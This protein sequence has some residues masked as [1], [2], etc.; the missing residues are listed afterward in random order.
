MYSQRFSVCLYHSDHEN[1]TTKTLRIVQCDRKRILS[2]NCEALCHLDKLRI[3]AMCNFI[4][5][6]DVWMC[7]SVYWRFCF[8]IMHRSN[9]DTMS[10]TTLL[11]FAVD[12]WF[13][14]DTAWFVFEISGSLSF[15]LLQSLTSV[16]GKVTTQIGIG[17]GTRLR[18]MNF[19]SSCLHFA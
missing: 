18:T 4:A 9:H 7:F 2:A 8:W 12:N 19:S 14:S 3:T 16:D 1:W 11:L 5:F 15:C 10:T 13:H 6:A 17:F